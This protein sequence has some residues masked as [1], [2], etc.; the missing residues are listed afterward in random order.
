MSTLPRV[1]AIIVSW[2]RI[3]PLQHCLDSLLRQDYENLDIMVLD[4]ASK[5]GTI[6][7]LKK[8]YS[9]KIGLLE[10]EDNLGAS[11]ARNLGVL[12]SMGKYL[13]FL[14]SDAELLDDWAVGR[15]V[16][17]LER[18]ANLAGT[19]GVIYQDRE[20]QHTWFRGACCDPYYYVDVTSHLDKERPIEILSTC[21]AVVRRDV[22]VKAGGFDTWYFYIHEDTDLFLRIR[23]MGYDYAID[24][25]IRIY[26]DLSSEGREDRD[27]YQRACHHEVRRIYIFLKLRGMIAY[28]KS[29]AGSIE[30]FRSVLDRQNV[31]YLPRWQEFVLFVLYPLRAIWLYPRARLA[32]RRNFLMEP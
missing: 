32:R 9:G 5:D 3:G 4:N 15:M 26:H 27:L 21:F 16:D 8:K 31:Q 7:L 11:R 29:L 10:L 18:N 2:N 20:C 12:D 19:S 25:N 13:L 24:E 30:H 6:K 1:C 14:D 28:L 22:F 23:D 17:M